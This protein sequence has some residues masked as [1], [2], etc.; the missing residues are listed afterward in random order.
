MREIIPSTVYTLSPLKNLMPWSCFMKIT[1][2]IASVQGLKSNLWKFILCSRRCSPSENVLFCIC[3][4]CC[5]F[6]TNFYNGITCLKLSLIFSNI[7][8][9]CIPYELR[10]GCCLHEL[11]YT[12]W[13][14]LVPYQS[15]THA[16]FSGRNHLPLSACSLCFAHL[17][18]L[19]KVKN[20]NDPWR[21]SWA[22]A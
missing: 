17:S 4:C 15:Y 10:H 20:L 2:R 7:Q 19:R 16:T 3:Y 8:G 13:C 5:F 21:K 12:C 6:S 22:D 1:C 11:L 9:F 14:D 18:M